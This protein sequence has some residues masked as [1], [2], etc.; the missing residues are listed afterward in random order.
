MKIQHEERNTPTFRQWAKSADIEPNS[1]F[2]VTRIF[3]NSEWKTITFV[4]ESF[5][6]NL[7]QPNTASFEKLRDGIRKIV[8]KPCVCIIKV[9][10]R[11]RSEIEL[12][13]ASDANESAQV[14]TQDDF[15]FTLA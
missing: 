12:V 9:Q 8:Q 3:A 5:R 4:T 13:P 6:I 11:E 2:K 14:F 1:S 7:K 10:D 15:G